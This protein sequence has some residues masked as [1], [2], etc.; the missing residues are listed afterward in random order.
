[1]TPPEYPLH[2]PFNSSLSISAET[3]EEA[4]DVF[5]LLHSD[6]KEE[7]YG[8]FDRLGRPIKLVKCGADVPVI[9]EYDLSPLDPSKL[10]TSRTFKL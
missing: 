1:M 5:E 7:V 4:E 2:V 8:I 3:L 6:G 9:V 10:A